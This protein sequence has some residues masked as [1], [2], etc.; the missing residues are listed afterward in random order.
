MPPSSASRSRRSGFTLIE[1]L[2][3]IA[4]IAILIGLLLP[5]VQKVREAAARIQCQNHLK[6]IGLACHNH[7]EQHGFFPT[8]GW[9]WTTPPTYVN[10]VPAAFADQQAGWGFQI[11]PFIEQDNVWRGAGATNDFDRALVAMATPINTFF[12]P[13][14][15]PPQTVRYSY[16]GYLGGIEAT[17]AL[18]DYAASNLEG[19]GVVR[20]YLPNRIAD[21]QGGTSNTLLIGEKRLNLTLLG[22]PQA[23]DNEGYTC[24]WNEDTVRFTNQRVSPD[25]LGDPS[26][27]GGRSIGSIS[28]HPARFNVVLADGFVGGISYSVSQPVFRA[29]GDKADG[30]VINPDEL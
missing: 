18:C 17:H 13:T 29:L 30:Q 12:C 15:R 6:Q 2:V 10:G 9:D 19:T 28:S 16:P 3:T 11:L 22:Q 26:L 1:L 25:F 4:I 8:G 24:G 21:I 14:R 7:H 27:F 5:A 20:Q 23:D